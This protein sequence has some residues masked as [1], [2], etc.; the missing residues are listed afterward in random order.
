MLALIVSTSEWSNGTGVC[1]FRGGGLF[2][3]NFEGILKQFKCG[4]SEQS[5]DAFAH[6]LKYGKKSLVGRLNFWG[7]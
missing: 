4:L 1:L 6:R 2:L 7:S 5:Q 3:W